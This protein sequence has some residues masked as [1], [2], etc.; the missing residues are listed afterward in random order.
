MPFHEFAQ[1]DADLFR[2]SKNNLYGD[3]R[4][5]AMGGAFGALGANL[6]SSQI[7]PA[8]FGRYS[9]SQF[10]GAFG[11]E[12][13]LNK[14]TYN[15]TENT[16]MNNLFHLNNLGFIAVEDQSQ[17]Q[18]GFL[19]SQIGFGFNRIQS[20]RS[21]LEFTGKNYYTMM[22]DFAAQARGYYP[23]DLY[24]YFP[25]SSSM[26]W[27]TY[28]INFDGIGQY[29]SV[30]GEGDSE[31][32]HRFKQRGSSNEMYLAF[33]GNYMN[34]LYIGANL[35][36]RWASYRSEIFHSERNY[37]TTYSDMYGFDYNYQ[38]RTNG[39][40]ANLKLGIIYLPVEQFRLGLAVHTPTF[41]EFKDNFSAD[42]TTFW[43]DTTREL[44]PSF[45]PSGDYKYRLRTPTKIVGSVAYVFGVRG[46]LS[47]DVEYVPYRTA[48]FRSTTDEEYVRY[49]YIE[50]NNQA[51]EVF[52]GGVNM[53]FGGEIVLNGIL[54]LRAG[55]A[56]QSNAY[57]KIYEVDAKWDQTLSGGFGLRMD[58][59]QLDLSVRKDL[60]Q[61]NYHP[62]SNATVA[63]QQDI[64]RIT[65][66][67]TYF[68]D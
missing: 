65:L 20:Y 16:G 35:G 29:Y 17:S 49:D 42:M 45:K 31:Q 2:Y 40:G 7:N 50:E 37:D 43:A 58:K 34:K 61:R 57:K 30:L 25:F 18:T 51:R 36:I 8:G 38:L 59:G 9:K 55:Y 27:E 11:Y 26:A 46:C 48:H 64:T 3:A 52:T 32:Q 6:A 24:T 67:Y 1:N 53:R 39:A 33:S 5:E 63:F 19:F 47:A 12:N 62:F 60:I 10:N 22:D 66:S 13:K 4:F 15:G 56:L 14:A 21:D 41:F 68:L 54:F 23:E 28:G 44:L